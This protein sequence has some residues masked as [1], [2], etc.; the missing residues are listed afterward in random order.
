MARWRD[1]DR[2]F[3]SFLTEDVAGRKWGTST[4]EKHMLPCIMSISTKL[5]SESI[6]RVMHLAQHQ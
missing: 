5:G 2:G 6:V 4:P 3:P 1:D